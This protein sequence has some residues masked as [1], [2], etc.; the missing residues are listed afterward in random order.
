MEEANAVKVSLS[1][2]ELVEFIMRDG[3]LDNRSSH[4][5]PDAMLEGSRLHRKIQ[6]AQGAGYRAEVPLKLEYPVTYDDEDIVFVIDGRADGIFSKVPDRQFAEPKGSLLCE[7]EITPVSD[8]FDENHEAKDKSDENGEVSDITS[9]AEEVTFIDEIKTS[10]GDVSEMEAPVKV[11]LAQ[12]KCYAFVYAR[13]SGLDAVGVQMT[14]CNIETEKTKKF[15]E[16][17][18]FEEISQWFYG[19]VHEYSK[20][21][22]RQIK[23]ERKR[24]AE[25]KKLEFPFSYREGQRDLVAGVYRT[26]AREKKLF[27]EAPTGVGKTISTVF[28]AVKAFAEGKACKIFYGTAKTI[29]R[30][31]AEEAFHLIQE[32]GV[33]LKN[34]T[35]TAKEKVC[36]LEKPNCNPE[37]CPRAKGHYDRVNDAVFDM[38]TNENEISREL[39]LKYAEKYSVCPFEMGLDVT[40]WADAVICDYNYIFDPDVYLRRF[41]ADGPKRDYV[42]LID[43]AHNLVERARE[44][45]SA[46]LVKEDF[47]KCKKM[48]GNSDPLHTKLS[49]ALEK[50]NKAML[51]IKRQCDDFAVWEDVNPLIYALMQFMSVYE[52]MPRFFSVDDQEMMSTLYLNVRHFINMSELM[53]D[54]YTIYSDYAGNDFRVHLQCM[55]PSANLKRCLEKGRSAVF[56]SA[57]LLPIK[58]YIGQLGGSFEEDY[59]VYA[60]SPFSRENRLILVGTDVSTRYA[61][62]TRTEYEKISRYVKEFT[63]AKKGNYMVFF[64]SYQ[65]MKDIADIILEDDKY[66]LTG[67][68]EELLTEQ[69]EDVPELQENI[70]SGEQPEGVYDLQSDDSAEKRT[71]T[72]MAAEAAG[73]RELT[74]ENP[75]N[76][77]LGGDSCACNINYPEKDLPSDSVLLR[78]QRTGMTETEKEEFLNFFDENSEFTRIGFCVMGGIF[79]EGIDLRADRLIGAVVVGTGLPQV[80]NE[81]ELFRNYYDEKN[82]SGFDYAYLY[83]GMNKVLQSAGRVI[84]TS[85]DKGA[86]LLLD[87][88][89]TQP[90]YRNLFPQEWFPYGLVTVDRVGNAVEE[91]WKKFG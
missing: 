11:H 74:G 76:G 55:D 1:V 60:P 90:S 73:V 41:F 42:F 54:D 87:E 4:A 3:D 82:G 18:S 67:R 62:R 48:V 88:R 57:T 49:A 68:T 25:I 32:K 53:G 31:V 27:L 72:V 75:A 33:P 30:T 12:A 39:I 89:F 6:K 63:G 56:F 51:V 83:N 26:I 15:E 24:N 58:Y 19:L 71:L 44:M 2:R 46:V 70:L 47:L 66:V 91:F 79:G 23:W 20:W 43:E 22:A 29:A 45:Y 10:Y 17:Y 34:V 21:V 65:M 7:K 85:E 37:A 64:P 84:R 50:C 16:C 52:S 81:R 28:P 61:R 69:T 36:V 59:A 8:S 5:D 40:T 38:L 35:I 13:Q 77:S 86:I 78:L 80:C 9:F 14:Y